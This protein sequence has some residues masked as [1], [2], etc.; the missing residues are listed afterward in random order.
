MKICYSVA[1]SLDG[2]IAGSNGEAD[3]IPSDPE[4]NFAEIW[5]RI[6]ILLM[7]RKT[8]EFAL[9]GFDKFGTQGSKIVVISRTLRSKDHLGV[10]IVSELEPESAA[11]CARKPG[12]TSGF[13]V[14][15]SCFVRSCA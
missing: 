8:Y 3:W 12:R 5:S 7:G 10:R 6:D 1:M 13:L 11:A 14:E 15:G 4:V 9:E 2:Y